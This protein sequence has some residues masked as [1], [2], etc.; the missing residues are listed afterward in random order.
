[1]SYVL[2]SDFPALGF[3]PPQRS[4]ADY[5]QAKSVV[6]E[7]R[8]FPEA[9]PVSDSL[10]AHQR[11]A[12]EFALRKGRALLAMDT[13]LGK[14]RAFL[15]WARIV[16]AHERR[17][18]IVLCPLAVA[19]QTVREGA[20]LGIEVA[21]CYDAGDVQ[22]GVNVA[23][24]DR[25]DKLDATVFGGVVLDESAILRD[26]T[27]S[28]KR[29]LCRAFTD[30][31]WRLCASATPAPNDWMEIG[32]QS[33]FLGIMPAPEML[34]RWFISA[35]NTAGKYRL[36][37]H[38]TRAF[39]DWVASWAFC[40]RHPRDLGFPGDEFD[41][42]P[43]D[44]RRHVVE[45]DQTVET[46]GALFRMPA[47][48]ATDVHREKRL[49]IDRRAALIGELV[50]R[51]PGEQWLVW[52]DTDYEADVLARVIPEVVEVRGSMPSSI[53]EDRLDRFATGEIRV[54][55]SKP[56]IAGH[57][58]NFQSCAR[59]AF[60]GISFS[61]D[62]TYQAIRR[63]WRYG[64]T[65]PVQVHMAMAET[66][67]AVWDSVNRKIT[68]HERMGDEMLKAMRRAI[69]SNQTMKDVYQPTYDGEFPEWS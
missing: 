57:G 69:S 52:C 65:R 42:P 37:G 12:A 66:E 33:E 18:V 17:P 59:M 23:N 30:T 36:K 47:L 62:A 26:W 24:Y 7:D 19:P 31:P 14:T 38:A 55:I 4:Y 5:L 61:F 34:S 13:G 40:M 8:G 60:V 68:Q 63:C 22:P 11:A 54:L 44:V 41:L 43:L 45:V 3:V 10:F 46:N 1:V 25:L 6:A 15:E 50:R 21:R 56:R 20:A 58:L 64:Q 9:P 49:T 67:V 28:T 2:S 29:A 35:D 51:E 16:A 53:K 39:W 27:G 48:S 32:N